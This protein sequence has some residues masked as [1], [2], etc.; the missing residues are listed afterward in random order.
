MN[1]TSFLTA[2]KWMRDLD[3]DAGIMKR[4]FESSVAYGHFAARTLEQISNPISEARRAALGGSL[5]LADTQAIRTASLLTPLA[6]YR[7]A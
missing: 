5:L 4:F 7:L 3:P 2:A 6:E 1:A